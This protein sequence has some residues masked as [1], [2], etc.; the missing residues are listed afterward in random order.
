MLNIYNSI[1]YVIYP[2]AIDNKGEINPNI[3]VMNINNIAVGIMSSIKKLAGKETSDSTPV[4]YKSIG[5][6]EMVAATVLATISR[7]PKRRGRN[8]NQFKT[9]G[10]KK[11]TPPVAI[12]DN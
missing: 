1:K 12:K 7:I 8:L 4:R 9:F 10:V 6:T 11:S 3:P 5:K 2:T